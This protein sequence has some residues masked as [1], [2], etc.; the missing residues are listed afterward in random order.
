MIWLW[1]G[2][3]S[4]HKVAHSELGEGKGGNTQGEQRPA[5]LLFNAAVQMIR[6]VSVLYIAF[7]Y[8]RLDC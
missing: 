2:Y 6:Y 8:C 4:T 1:P 5:S 7:L 3:G